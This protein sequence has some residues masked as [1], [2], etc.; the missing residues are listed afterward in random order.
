M[1]PTTLLRLYPRS[2]RDRYGAEFLAL[3]EKEGTG[4]RVVLNVMAGAFDAWSSP[5]TRSQMA[6]DGPFGPSLL[7]RKLHTTEGLYSASH[8]RHLVAAI[9]AGFLV[10]AAGIPFHHGEGPFAFISF[11]TGFLA[12]IQWWNFRTFSVRTRLAAVIWALVLVPTSAFAIHTLVR[13]LVY[14]WLGYET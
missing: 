4:P 2:W 12:A 5:R 8:W 3:L 11:F 9:V 13:V 6:I 7:F 1:K 14:R 10:Q